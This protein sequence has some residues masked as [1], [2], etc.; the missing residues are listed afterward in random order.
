[1]ISLSLYL[2]TIVVVASICLCVSTYSLSDDNYYSCHSRKKRKELSN[3]LE[4]L[5]SDE[6]IY[7]S[8]SNNNRYHPTVYLQLRNKYLKFNSSQET[9]EL[10]DTPTAIPWR[11]IVTIVT[12]I[13]SLTGTI[14][15]IVDKNTL[16]SST[17]ESL[18]I[19][20]SDIQ[21]KEVHPYMSDTTAQI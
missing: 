5:K 1:M 13:N 2:I 21:Q 4:S 15:D 10:S 11:D 16:Q 18:D 17:F 20:F 12:Y 3:F 8:P 9:L 19:Y 14:F 6:N 7:Y